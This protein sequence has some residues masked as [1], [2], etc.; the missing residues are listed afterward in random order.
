[1]ALL[2]G[3]VSGDILTRWRRQGLSLKSPE[4]GAVVMG[5]PIFREGE[6]TLRSISE[7]VHTPLY[8]PPYSPGLNPIAEK[9][10]LRLKR[11]GEYLALS[12]GL[13]P[14]GA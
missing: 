3:S 10:G 5:N 13:E 14:Y 1:V 12:S 6:E 8:L 4:R 11:T 2:T 9:R 7:E